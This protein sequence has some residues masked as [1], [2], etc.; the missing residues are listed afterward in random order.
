[1]TAVKN[2]RV[3]SFVSG[4]A[5]KAPCIVVSA[6]NL[7]LSGEQTVNTIPVFV[8]DRVLVIAQT[9]PVENGIYN[10]E[11]SAW[12]RAGDFDGNRDATRGTQ[13]AV[14]AAAGAD[15]I[16]QLDSANP[17][18]IGVDSITWTLKAAG[19]G[20]ASAVD[21]KIA[22]ADQDFSSVTPAAHDQLKG[23]IMEASKLYRVQG[24]VWG[25]AQFSSGGMR[26]EW[27][28]DNLPTGGEFFSHSNSASGL[29]TVFRNVRTIQGNAQ[30]VHSSIP[31]FAE[32]RMEISGLIRANAAGT[33][34]DWEV[35][36]NSASAN[37]TKIFT[38]SW[39]ELELLD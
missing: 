6:A 12:Q 2:F 3:D 17:V 22:T 32:Y 39:M 8:G 30:H 21:R 25:K 35:G 9:D 14:T 20:G 28:Y 31:N 4:L 27:G 38:G 5:F 7:T 11:S 26:W 19:G 37:V 36:Q 13:V 24:Q 23:W 15:D 29:S 18:V 10:V 34:L 33:V 1:M 16:Y